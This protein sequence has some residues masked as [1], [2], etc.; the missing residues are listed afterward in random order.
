MMN[1][2]KMR[3]LYILF[4]FLLS[5]K[6]HDNISIPSI[7]LEVCELP[8]GEYNTIFRMSP[9]EQEEAFRRSARDTDKDGMSDSQDNCRGVFNPD[10][11]D[12]DKDGIGDACDATPF[13]PPPAFGQWVIFLDLDG[14]TVNTPYHNNG[15][16]FYATPSGLNSTEINNIVDSVRKDFEQFA[17]IAITTDSNVY[18]AA[19]L[20]RRQRVIVTEFNE[21]YGN[22]GGIAY[23]G[24][25]DFGLEIPCFVFSKALFYKQK[26]IAETISHESGHTL[27]LYHQSRC[28]GTTFISEYNPGFG[29]GSTSRAPIMGSSIAR[30][31]Y[32][33][34]GPNS[35]GCSNIQNDSLVIRQK[36]GF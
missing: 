11:L 26:S 35:F 28:D 4:I 6:K 24:S 32:W 2:N 21:W 31:G 14:H 12:S 34:I 36:V 27:G 20:V 25:I 15:V 1:D 16:P 13:P 22:V 23:I 30:I 9:K 29:T 8:N 18:N 10:Q 19:S 17:P 33:W 3:L 5:C 7:K